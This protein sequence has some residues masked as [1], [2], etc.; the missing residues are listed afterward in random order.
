MGHGFN[1]SYSTDSVLYG[2]GVYFSRYAAYSARYTD[3]KELCFLFLNRVLV[4]HHTPGSTN[5]RVPP[6]IVLPDGRQQQADS[7][8]DREEPYSMA[9]TF[10]DDQNYPEFMISYMPKWII[11][12]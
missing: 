11:L 10:H 12:I 4:G 8:T 5:L 7:T 2:L 9:C 6:N 3:G 1:R